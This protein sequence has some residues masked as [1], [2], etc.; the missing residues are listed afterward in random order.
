VDAVPLA[1][2]TI[3]VVNED[4]GCGDACHCAGWTQGTPIVLNGSDTDSKYVTFVIT[5]MPRMG[6]LYTSTGQQ[7]QFPFTGLQVRSTRGVA[8]L[9]FGSVC[10][11]YIIF[12]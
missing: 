6:K 9:R 8:R 10:F 12:V 11:C 4:C 7:I 2:K 1:G 5:E 3:G